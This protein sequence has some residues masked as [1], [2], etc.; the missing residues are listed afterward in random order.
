MKRRDALQ[1]L[2]SV[3]AAWVTAPLAQQPN[4]IPVVGVPLIA[5]GP[6]DSIMV[7]LRRGLSERGY[8]D[9]E[10]IRI[11]HRSAEGKVERLPALLGELLQLKVDVI[12]AG[13][14]PIVKA[15]RQATSTTPIVMVSW[16]YDPVA[17][18]LVESLNKP[19]GNV[20]GVYT[21][22]EETVGKRLELLKDLLPGVSRIAILYD[23]FGKHQF[24][25]I[26]PAAGVLR[27]QILPIEIHEP[28]DFNAAFKRAKIGK[29]GAVSVLFS[30]HFYVNR[31][32]LADAALAQQLPTMFQEYASVRAGG[33]ISYGPSPTDAWMR[34][35]YFIDRILKGARPSE[36]PIEQPNVYSMLV[37]MKTAKALGITIPESIRLRADEVLR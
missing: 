1:A 7:E 32:R 25:R 15:A 6:N 18:G 10:N 36:L 3:L 22:V 20:T 26:G 28:Y 21:R 24:E 31:Q 11:E 35:G 19:G 13:A 23:S 4:K 27:L 37:N 17:A 5:A 2:C 34:A 30:P 12:V 8:V 33:L 9:G 29:A 16:D 14:Q